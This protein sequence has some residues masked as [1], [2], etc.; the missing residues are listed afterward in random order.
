M[1]RWWTCFYLT[2]AQEFQVDS[3]HVR[4]CRSS[5]V[6]PLSNLPATSPLVIRF[7]EPSELVRTSAFCMLLVVLLG[8]FV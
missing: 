5:C 8:D 4:V 2:H 6:H 3:P 1:I 7:T